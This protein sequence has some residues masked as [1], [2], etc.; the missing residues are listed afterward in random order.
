[1]RIAI[2]IDA[3]ITAYPVFFRV[4]TAALVDDHEIHIL[5]DRHPALDEATR[6]LLADLGIRYHH[7][8][9]TPDKHNYILDRGIEVLFDDSDHYYQ[10]LPE[11]VAVFKCRQHYN[12]DF[13]TGRWY[14][15]D[16]TGRP[17][18]TEA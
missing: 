11:S 4:L 10:H 2:D 17:A 15:T 6:K 7:L 16:A 9:I 14:Y 8:A 5:T 13:D 12:F 3:T 1:M 18:P